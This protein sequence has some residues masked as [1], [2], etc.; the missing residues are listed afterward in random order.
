MNF[1]KLLP[2]AF[3]LGA[4]L[5]VLGLLNGHRTTQ[6]SVATTT[7]AEPQPAPKAAAPRSFFSVSNTP[8]Q[9]VLTDS[10]AKPKTRSITE[11]TMSAE[12]VVQLTGVVGQDTNTVIDQIKAL[13]G[14]SSEPIFMLINSPGGSVMSSSLIVSA[15]QASRAP[16]VTV[17]TALCAS[18][19]FI[20]LEYGDKRFAVDRAI[21]MSHP[22]SIGGQNGELDKA[23][24]FLQSIQRYVDKH[25]SYIANRVGMDYS[26]FKARSSVEMW[27]D[28]EDAFNTGFVDGVAAL[29]VLGSLPPTAGAE[30]LYE[31]PAKFDDARLE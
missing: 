31:I 16:I 2:Y 19:A 1:N 8:V 29:N 4:G 22:A 3:G 12:R 13:N 17:C 5:V 18:M 27:L 9:S 14:I 25:N 6:A 23:V 20:I 26:E 7:L 28:A 24:S 30:G 15:M 21:I 11:L 10:R